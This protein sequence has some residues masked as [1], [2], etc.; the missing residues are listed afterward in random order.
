MRSKPKTFPTPHIGHSR[1]GLWKLFTLNSI[2][3]NWMLDLNWQLKSNF[4][5]WVCE[6]FNLPRIIWPNQI[7]DVIFK[8]IS[9]REFLK[10]P[11]K[12]RKLVNFDKNYCG[13]D[14]TITNLA[15]D[16]DTKSSFWEKLSYSIEFLNNVKTIPEI[17]S[18]SNICK[19]FTSKVYFTFSKRTV[20]CSKQSSH[21]FNLKK[22]Q[23]IDLALKIFSNF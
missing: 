11:F 20:Q 22:F 5:K 4:R 15:T 18:R 8:D 2:E 16:S 1:H 14:T 17:Q 9:S 23:K 7:S 3:Y 19:C 6:E 21:S 12:N 10:K 13:P